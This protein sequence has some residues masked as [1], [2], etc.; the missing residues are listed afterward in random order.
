MTSAL[1]TAIAAGLKMI[2]RNSGVA[3]TVTRG[4]TTIRIPDA[5]QG[6]S[7]KQVI[8][9]AAETVVEACDWLISVAG[10]TLGQPAIGDIISRSVNGVAYTWTVECPAMGISHFDWSDT[11]RTQY[12]IRTRKDGADAFEVI[13]PNGFD[14]AGSEMRYA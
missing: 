13:K 14:L 4:G 3:V 9:E 1:E 10:Y 8:D 6:Q 11:A 2:R 7:Q 12:R 5:V